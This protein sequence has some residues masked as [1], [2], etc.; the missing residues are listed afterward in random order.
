MTCKPLVSGLKFHSPFGSVCQKF[1]SLLQFRLRL[2][3]IYSLINSLYKKKKKQDS[4]WEKGFG[5]FIQGYNTSIYSGSQDIIDEFGFKNLDFEVQL[6]S[7]TRHTKPLCFAYISPQTHN[8]LQF[9]ILIIVARGRHSTIR[10]DSHLKLKSI[11]NY[12]IGSFRSDFSNCFLKLV[13]LIF[14]ALGSIFDL[15]SFELGS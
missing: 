11:S 6:M 8:N 4:S 14:T 2:S 5:L 9:G 10:A 3:N 12:L 13:S 15:F 1:S 7:V